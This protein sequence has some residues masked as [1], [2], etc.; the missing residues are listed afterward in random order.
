MNSDLKIPFNVIDEEVLYVNHFD[1]KIS[2]SDYIE[3]IKNTSF[4]IID[5]DGNY[6][7]KNYK[8]IINSET[9]ECYIQIIDMLY[10][11]MIVGRYWWYHYTNV[12]CQGP[13]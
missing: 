5:E 2:L 8:E 13:Q 9:D 7:T 6:T 3:Y 1:I 12:C 4:K 10:N 11:D